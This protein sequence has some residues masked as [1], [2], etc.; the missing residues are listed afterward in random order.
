METLKSV[1]EAATS[2]TIDILVT[3][4]VYAHNQAA[5]LDIPESQIRDSFE[6]NVLGNLSLI[7]NFLAITSSSPKIILDVSSAAAFGVYP[8]TSVYG[9]SKYALSFIIKHIQNENPDKVRVHSFH[10]GVVWT[11]AVES[12]A[13]KKEHF[14]TVLDNVDLPG[15]FAVWLASEQ[16]EFLKGRYVFA[17]WD[18]ED[19]VKNKEAFESDATLATVQLK[20]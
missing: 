10:P 7:T 11:P 20:V 12:F 18:V 6:T 9:A 8:F 17:K 3:S 1:M 15:R 13:V 5:T 14:E 2:H 19:L 16:A 4:A